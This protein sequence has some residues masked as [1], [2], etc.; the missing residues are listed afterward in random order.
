MNARTEFQVI[1]GQDGKPAFVVVPFEQ[2]RHM[3]GGCTRG[4]ARRSREP[5][6]LAWALR[7]RCAARALRADTSLSCRTDRNHTKGLRKDG[8]R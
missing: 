4:T 8:A 3:K 5:A 2:F 6:F 7:G 1:V